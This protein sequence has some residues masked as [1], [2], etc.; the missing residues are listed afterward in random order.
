M[1]ER[2]SLQEHIK[3]KEKWGQIV[4]DIFQLDWVFSKWYD[5]IIVISSIIWS[6]WSIIKFIG[7]LF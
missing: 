4:R 5:K 1:N 3:S 7:G 6:I 2:K